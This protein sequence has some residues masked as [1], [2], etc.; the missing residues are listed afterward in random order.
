MFRAKPGK[1]VVGIENYLPELR[2]YAKEHYQP[3]P[4]PEYRNEGEK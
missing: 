3:K 2:L 4:K 1:P